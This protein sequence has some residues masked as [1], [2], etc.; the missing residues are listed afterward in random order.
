MPRPD[1][2]ALVEGVNDVPLAEPRA[3][4]DLAEGAV[5]H[6]ISGR[7]ALARKGVAVESAPIADVTKSNAGPQ[8]EPRRMRR[9]FRRLV[10]DHRWTRRHR[11]RLGR[12]RL[13]TWRP[14]LR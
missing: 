2:I 11:P 14:V 1:E 4:V 8:R 13:V 3:D 9:H 12:Q 6:E 5:C 10:L 7:F